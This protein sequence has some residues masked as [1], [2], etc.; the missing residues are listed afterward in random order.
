MIFTNNLYV[1]RMSNYE[2]AIANLEKAKELLDERYAKKQISDSDYIKK[3][4]E[5]NTQIENYKKI[6][7][8]N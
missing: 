5:I 7:N 6:T 3:S 2:S 8:N 4:K 1:Q